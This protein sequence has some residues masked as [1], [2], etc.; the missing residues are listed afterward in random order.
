MMGGCDSKHNGKENASPKKGK[1]Y[2]SEEP[3]AVLSSPDLFARELKPEMLGYA[4]FGFPLPMPGAPA[5]ELDHGLRVLV[6]DRIVDGFARRPK[7]G[8]LDLPDVEV[9]IFVE[10]HSRGKALPFPLL[11]SVL[12]EPFENAYPLGAGFFPEDRGQDFPAGHP[13]SLSRRPAWREAS[14]D[15]TTSE[16]GFILVRCR[17]NRNA[18][19][20]P[21][22]GGGDK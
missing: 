21:L 18:K 1:S 3:V 12:P 4:G 6:D 14:L 10:V 8:F 20:A 15:L 17:R 11:L 5:V 9:E 22:P 2:P 13:N 7:H 16:P 19:S